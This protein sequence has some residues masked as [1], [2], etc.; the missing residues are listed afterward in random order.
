MSF[1]ERYNALCVPRI[2][3]IHWTTMAQESD[4]SKY[5]WCSKSHNGRKE[6]LAYIRRGNSKIKDSYVKNLFLEKLPVRILRGVPCSVRFLFSF[7]QFRSGT[8]S[9]LE[10][11]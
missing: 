2:D 1:E 8:S 7:V 11:I 5:C 9:L 10:S 4:K 6:A 3:R